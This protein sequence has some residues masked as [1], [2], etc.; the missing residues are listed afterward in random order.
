M[1][2]FKDLSIST[3]NYH[4]CYFDGPIIYIDI[5]FPAAEYMLP[6]NRHS[7]TQSEKEIVGNLQIASRRIFSDQEALEM[8]QK[9]DDR[10][11]GVERDSDGSWSAFSSS[12][13]R[14]ES[15]PPPAKKR[16]SSH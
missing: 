3:S 13:S 9:L 2:L 1:S 10:D 11:S 16:E 4:S 7:R 12:D 15:E 14:S 5:F 8:L 6:S